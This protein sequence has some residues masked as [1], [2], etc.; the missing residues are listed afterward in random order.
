MNARIEAAAAGSAVTGSM[1]MG[2]AATLLAQ[3]VQALREG[4]TTFD[5][6]AVTEIDSSGLAVLFGWQRAAQAG[7]KTITIVN[8]PHNLRSLA[9]VYDV[10]GLLSLS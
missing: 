5:L 10:T 7:G 1:T 3:G 9:D 8:P 6:S 2:S 4:R